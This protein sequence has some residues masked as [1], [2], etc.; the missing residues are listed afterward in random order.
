VFVFPGIGL[1]A[2]VA[3]ARE[4]TD[5]AFLVA[6]HEL[7]SAVSAERLAAGAIYPPITELRSVAQRIAIALVRHFRDSGYGRQYHDDEVEP[8]VERA[9]WFPDYL[10]LD[11]V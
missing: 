10:A 1:G 3:E 9:M 7:A 11:P 5:E 2:I 8:A 6:A 4:L